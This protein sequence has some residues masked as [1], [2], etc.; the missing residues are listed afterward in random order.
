MKTLILFFLITVSANSQKFQGL[1][2]TMGDVYFDAGIGGGY[3]ILLGDLNPLYNNGY[4]L[5]GNLQAIIHER[6]GLELELGFQSWTRITGRGEPEQFIDNY[7]AR[8]NYKYYWD[9]EGDYQ[10]FI[11]G[12]ASYNNLAYLFGRRLNNDLG[13][14]L[15]RPAIVDNSL[16]VHLFFGVSSFINEHI[17]TDI[18]IAYNRIF[19]EKAINFLTIDLKAKYYF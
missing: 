9:N 2:Q 3:T 8:L 12:G 14:D 5:N 19:T 13:D 16:G 15:I 17:G 6:Y 4:S 18:I 11:G 1:S 10:N 7:I